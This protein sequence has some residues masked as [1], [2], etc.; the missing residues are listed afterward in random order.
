[1]WKAL[2]LFAMGVLSLPAIALSY[3]AWSNPDQFSRVFLRS[4][5]RIVKEMADHPGRVAGKQLAHL[6]GVVLCHGDHV[7][8]DLRLFREQ[9]HPGLRQLL[10]IPQHV[11]RIRAQVRVGLSAVEQRH[12]VAGRE[13]AVDHGGADKSGAADDEYAH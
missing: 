9:R 3:F 13:E 11:L 2:R 5:G 4:G 12:L 7:D 1:M 8:D 6:P 10:A